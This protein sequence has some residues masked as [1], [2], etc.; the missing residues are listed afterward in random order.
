MVIKE[1]MPVLLF[2][3]FGPYLMGDRLRIKKNYFGQEDIIFTF[4]KNV[5]KFD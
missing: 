1:R 3:V 5:E 4:A 2:F